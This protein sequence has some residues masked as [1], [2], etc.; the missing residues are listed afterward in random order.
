[1]RTVD[2]ALD[3]SMVDMQMEM[4]QPLNAARQSV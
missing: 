3:G 1:M 2:I 4:V